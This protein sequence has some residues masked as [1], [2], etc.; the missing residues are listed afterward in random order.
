MVVF[1]RFL[2]LFYSLFRSSSDRGKTEQDGSTGSCWVWLFSV[3][4]VARKEKK[5]GKKGGSFPM[6]GR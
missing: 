4:L 3:V 2:G 5:K 1:P 6:E